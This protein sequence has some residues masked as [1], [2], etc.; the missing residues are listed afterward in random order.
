MSQTHALAAKITTAV[1]DRI[2]IDRMCNSANIGDAV[3]RELAV[4]SLPQPSNAPA[5]P[6]RAAAENLIRLVL[7]KP[8]LSFNT[9]SELD[10]AIAKVYHALLSIGWK[11][12]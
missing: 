11:P 10:A 5:D 3:V 1:I 6:V 9:P 2:A 7:S 8:S 4:A 12:W